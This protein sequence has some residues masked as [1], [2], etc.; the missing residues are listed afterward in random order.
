MFLKQFF[1]I[2][3]NNK[4]Q[5]FAFFFISRNKFSKSKKNY[6]K[7]SVKFTDFFY[8]RNMSSK[9]PLIVNCFI[10]S[11]VTFSNY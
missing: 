8:V 7:S 10:D 6:L 11:Q 5:E 1:N 2:L 9:Y 4:Y 3:N